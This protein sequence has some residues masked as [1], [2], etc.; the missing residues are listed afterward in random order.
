M[1]DF[2][3]NQVLPGNPQKVSVNTL[4]QQLEQANQQAKD[5]AKKAN[6]I[7]RRLNPD[8][9]LKT[10]V[11]DMKDFLDA[12]HKV[13]IPE[14]VEKMFEQFEQMRADK[15]EAE[16]G[17]NAPTK[18]ELKQVVS[19][20]KDI[21][22]SVLSS[23]QV[24]KNPVLSK[25]LKSFGLQDF[26]KPK[27]ISKEIN[28]MKIT[29]EYPTSMITSFA[30][31]YASS[32]GI[33]SL[34]FSRSVQL[35]QM[36]LSVVYI[37]DVIIT[38][39]LGL[40]DQYTNIEEVPARVRKICGVRLLA[41]FFDKISDKEL[42]MFLS[43]YNEKVSPQQEDIKIDTKEFVEVKCPKCGRTEVLPINEGIIPIRYCVDD[44]TLMETQS[45]NKTDENAPLA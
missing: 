3:P 27:T 12:N 22:D 31:A 11:Y 21:E 4:T 24:T 36:A 32:E 9:D 5:L 43:F 39:V 16:E 33:G 19:G 26:S 8:D 2:N 6:N 40:S 20:K 1:S 10:D 15:K 45:S 14:D 37:D 38:T 35:M 28:G 23:S 29:F 25:L 42:D 13:I 44:G 7:W 34:D 17:A 30:L 41:N 18:E